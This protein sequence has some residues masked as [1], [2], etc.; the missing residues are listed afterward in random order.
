MTPIFPVPCG[1]FAGM[2]QQQLLDARAAA[3]TALQAL[4]MGGKPQALSYTQGTG[5]KSVTYTP[6]NADKLQ[7]FIRQLNAALGLE[8][9]A[10]MAMVFR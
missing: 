3:Q 6:A 1:I 4:M 8:R 10:P 7:Y 9:R 2:T 5:S